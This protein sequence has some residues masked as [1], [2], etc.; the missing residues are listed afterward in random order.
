M[1]RGSGFDALPNELFLL[2]RDEISDDPRTLKALALVSKRCHDFFNSFLYRDVG[3]KAL[4][5]L[6]LSEKSRWPWTRAHPASFVKKLSVSPTRKLSATF[7][8]KSR[9]LLL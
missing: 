9:W 4:P 7:F 1:N 5:T 8:F 6:A 2:I 3:N